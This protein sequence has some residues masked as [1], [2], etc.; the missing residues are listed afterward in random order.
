MAKQRT[1]KGQWSSNRAEAKFRAKEAVLWQRARRQPEAIDVATQFGSTRA[2]RWAGAG[3]PVV[4]LHGMTDTSVRWIPYAD[5]LDSH[6]VYAIDIMGDVGHSKPDIGFSTADDY[7]TWLGETLDALGIAKPHIVGASLGGYIALSYAMRPEGVTSL[8]GFEPVGVVDLKLLTLMSWSVRCGIAAYAPD[9]VRRRL[10]RRLRQPLLADKEAMALLL[11]AQR[12]HPIKI[13]PCPVFTDEQ[14]Q[15]ITSPVHVLAGADSRA[16]D[17]AQL[18]DR[19][20]ETTP[21]GTARLL[22]EAGHGLTDGHF[23]DCVAVIRQA[24]ASPAKRDQQ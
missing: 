24:I 19:I 21:M 6:G 7:T 15:S 9:P 23:D 5:A 11:Q 8:V 22:P 13:P 2:Y 12:G 17:A 10:A 4:F 18:V 14:L 3:T 16:F 20:N 1:Y